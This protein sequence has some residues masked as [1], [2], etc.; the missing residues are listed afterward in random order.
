MIVF[1]V[2]LLM[3]GGCW[4]F[5]IS[6]GESARAAI[7]AGILVLLPVILAGI[8]ITILLEDFVIPLMYKYL[9]TTNEAW[10]RF[11]GIH[12]SSTASFVLY[13]FWKMLLW[14]A[15]IG[16]IRASAF[17]RDCACFAVEARAELRA[18]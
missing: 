17:A 14:I 2:V 13:A 18:I 9:L 15:A 12:R 10:R 6:M 3:A 7:I 11:L 16:C 8:Y 1:G 5:A 4:L